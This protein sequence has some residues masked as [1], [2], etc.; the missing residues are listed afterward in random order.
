MSST[1]NV[2]RRSVSDSTVLQTSKPFITG[3]MTSSRTSAAL[4]LLVVSS[5][6]PPLAAVPRRLLLGSRAMQR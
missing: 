2:L 1:M 5:A 4:S 6:T 3:I